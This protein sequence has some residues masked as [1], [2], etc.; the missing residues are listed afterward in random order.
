MIDKLSSDKFQTNDIEELINSLDILIEQL[1]KR[2]LEELKIK[3]E[4]KNNNKQSEI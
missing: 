3:T 2:K 4:I 1:H